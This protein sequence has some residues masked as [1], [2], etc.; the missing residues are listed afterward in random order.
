MLF[1]R[2]QFL[3]S[4]LKTLSWCTWWPPGWQTGAYT[5]E[6]IGRQLIVK[7]NERTG[8]LKTLF[9]CELD[10]YLARQYYQLS[11]DFPHNKSLKL[12]V[13]IRPNMQNINQATELNSKL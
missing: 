7:V 8:N 1:H 6:L 4:Y 9:Q 3:L 11:N 12:V 10:S 13:I 5:I 2:Q